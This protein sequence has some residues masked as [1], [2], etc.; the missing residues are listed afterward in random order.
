MVDTRLIP[1]TPHPILP[2]LAE[3]LHQLVNHTLTSQ[4]F[5]QLAEDLYWSLLEGQYRND[6]TIAASQL[7]ETLSDITV[8]WELLVGDR[9]NHPSTFIPEFPAEWVQQWLEQIQSIEQ[10]PMAETPKNQPTFHINQVGNINAGASRFCR[11]EVFHSG[12]VS[13]A[14]KTLP[15]P[16]QN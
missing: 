11:F 12:S 16:I 3:S 8:Q 15:L 2:T 1:P 5:V 6:S 4:R 14:S 10:I 13:L 9:Q 7:R